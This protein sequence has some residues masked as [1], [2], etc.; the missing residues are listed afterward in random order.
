MSKRRVAYYYDPDAGA[1]TY[2]LGHLMKP[3]RIR[4]T[5]ELVTA[6]DMLGMHV[7]KPKRASPEAMTMFHTDEYIHSSIE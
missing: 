1:Y 6:Y 2:G 7:L 4:V 3:H 5:H